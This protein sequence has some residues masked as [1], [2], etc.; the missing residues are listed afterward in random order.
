MSKIISYKNK[1]TPTA[2]ESFRKYVGKELVKL[3]TDYYKRGDLLHE[4]GWVSFLPLLKFEKDY[5]NFLCSDSEIAQHEN[6]MLYLRQWVLSLRTINSNIVMAN[7]ITK[8]NSDQL[9]VVEKPPAALYCQ[10]KMEK[11]FQEHKEQVLKLF[12]TYHSKHIALFKQEVN[13]HQLVSTDLNTNTL[14]ECIKC[15]VK[16]MDKQAAELGYIYNDDFS[17]SLLPVFTKNIVGPWHLKLQIDTSKMADKLLSKN[18]QF[19]LFVGIMSKNDDMKGSF[20]NFSMGDLFPIRINFAPIISAYNNFQSIAELETNI[21]AHIEMYK[22]VQPLLE[23]AVTNGIKKYLAS[24][25]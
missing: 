21:L 24:T 22:I 17:S 1:S 5:Q 10:C 16:I 12:E 23:P 20:G 4:K 25:E 3:A 13:L 2:D 18:K 14:D 7:S 9:L 19:G 6:I 11:Q 15:F 8:S